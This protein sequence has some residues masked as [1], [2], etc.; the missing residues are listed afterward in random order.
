MSSL[1]PPLLDNPRWQVLEQLLMRL[2]ALSRQSTI[3][4][5]VDITHESAL[6]HLAD[7]LS[8]DGDGWE[9]ANTVEA[10]RAL[11]K[12]A[13]QLHRKKGTRFAVKRT[14]ATLGYADAQITERTDFFSH[15]GSFTHN[16]SRTYQLPGNWTNYRVAMSESVTIPEATHIRKMLRGVAP[17]RCYLKGI[18]YPAML[19]DGSFTF[20]GTYNYGVA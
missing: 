2:S 4:L 14:L 1:L 10:K 12:E 8:L 17:A 9:M 11:L 7:Q 13:I 18:D 5:L 16:A 6:D 3:P 15:D 19:H 20:N